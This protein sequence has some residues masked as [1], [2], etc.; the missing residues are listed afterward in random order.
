MYPSIYLSINLSITLFQITISIA[1]TARRNS[2]IGLSYTS[3]F[4]RLQGVAFNSWG[5]N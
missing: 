2:L 5:Q 4:H 1:Q 3:G